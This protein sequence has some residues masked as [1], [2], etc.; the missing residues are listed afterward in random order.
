MHYSV[1]ELQEANREV[2]LGRKSLNC[3]SCGRGGQKVTMMLG[4]D[5]KQYKKE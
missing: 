5:G 1:L 2:L 4:S 3:L